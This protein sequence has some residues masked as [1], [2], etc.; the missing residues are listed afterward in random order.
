MNPKNGE[1]ELPYISSPDEVID[2]MAEYTLEGKWEKVIDIYY[3][4]PASHTAKINESVGTAL[5][6]AV[7][8][9]EER[10]VQELVNAIITRAVERQSA[11]IEALEIGNERG[12]TPL[13]VAAARGFAKICKWI[14]GMNKE[15]IYL[16][17][18]KNKHGETPLFQ[19]AINWKKKAFA[20]LSHISGHSAPLQ[21]LVRG[22][23]DTILH[24]AI[25]RE[26][27]DLAVII[28]HH[29]DF[30][31]THKNKEGLT[32]LTVLA[33]R[34]SAFRSASKLSWWKLILYHC[35]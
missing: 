28:V 32:P 25:R 4:F 10:V 14:I 35:K 9:D 20:Y 26:Y 19:A 17:S 21:D 1:E 15:R 27:F 16:A 18:R 12:D 5:H 7:D 2:Y 3:K 11:K 31:S 30:L 29:Y 13:H 24:C 23:G 34:P 33:T 6:V 22:N 8:L